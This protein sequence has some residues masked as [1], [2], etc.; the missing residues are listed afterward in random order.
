MRVSGFRKRHQGTG[1]NVCGD[2][3]KPLK[4]QRNPVAQKSKP[5]RVTPTSVDARRTG[6]KKSSKSATKPRTTPL[7]TPEPSPGPENQSQ[8]RR[9]RQD[10]SPSREER[11]SGGK[12]RAPTNPDN[13][14]PAIQ[15]MPVLSGLGI[16][17]Q[18]VIDDDDRWVQG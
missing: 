4:E 2:Q 1:P 8:R 10:P 5:Q 9:R 15:A 7:S 6:L 14:R 11:N 17:S 18:K 3:G 16:R 13:Q 12:V